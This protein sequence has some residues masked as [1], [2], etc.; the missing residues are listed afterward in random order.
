MP[1]RAFI[2]GV[3]TIAPLLSQEEWSRIKNK[4]DREVKLACCN[5]SGHLRRSK[6]GTQHFVHSRK[7]ECDWKPETVQH[8]QAKALVAIACSQMGYTVQTEAS[9]SG[10]RADVLAIKQGTHSQIKLA[11]E[12][13]WSPQ[14]LE[15]TEERQAKYT[16]DGIR[17]CWL[18]RKLPNSEER[19]DLPMFQL[20]LKENN[21]LNVIYREIYIP[22]SDFVKDLLSKHIKFCNAYRFKPV[23]QVKIVFLETLCWKCR[24]LHNIYYVENPYLSC[25]GNELDNFRF[26]G[27]DLPEIEFRAEII[28]AVNNYLQ[29]PEGQKLHVGRIKKRYSKTLNSSYLSFGCPWCDAIVGQHYVGEI[30][31]EAFYDDRIKPVWETTVDVPLI[32]VKGCPHWC[33]ST[34]GNFCD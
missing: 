1:L 26:N 8:L 21:Q 20:A 28:T 13:Q 25:C 22:L 7:K 3:E 32:R 15:V 23:Q 18:F 4:R 11:F 14:T 33:Y 31:M 5:A 17:C 34:E 24:K 9:G 27:S 10:W 16:R 12:I 6:L 29:T 19:A 30:I 2:Y